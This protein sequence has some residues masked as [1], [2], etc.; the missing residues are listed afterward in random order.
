MI[1]SP[2]LL[3]SILKMRRQCFVLGSKD[4]TLPRIEISQHL[5]KPHT[6]QQIEPE[7][8]LSHLLQHFTNQM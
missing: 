5:D 6:L 2:C 4:R 8:N 7:L 3:I 1:V